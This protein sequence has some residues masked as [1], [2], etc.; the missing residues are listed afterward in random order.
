MKCPNCGQEIAA[1]HLYC[2]KC[3]MEIRI[4]PDFEPEIE[5]SITETLST[6]AEAIEEKVPEKKEGRSLGEKHAEGKRRKKD[7]LGEESGRNWMLVRMVSFISVMLVAVFVV[8]FIYFNYS[9]SYQVE[10]ARRYAE[11]EKYEEA[12]TY[13][14]KA[15][16]LDR[17]NVEIVLLKANYCYAMGETKLA[18]DTL[19]ALI[20][21]EQMEY[22]NA[23]K[24]Y[25][26]LIAIYDVQGRYEEINKL[27]LECADDNIVTLF[28][29]YMAMEP[30]FSYVGG[31]YDEIVPLKLSANTTG[32]IYY[33]VDG[34]VPTKNSKV[35]TAPIFL[36][37][38]KYQVSAFFVNDYGI[39]SEVVKNWYEINLTI[40]EK[41]QVL[42]YSGKYEVPTKIAVEAAQEGRIYYTTDGSEPN[43]DSFVYTEPIDMPLG[44]SNFKF[45]VISEAGV[46]SDIVSRSFELKLNTNV[47]TD[48]AIDRIKKALINRDVL[49][50]MQGNAKATEGKYIF[51]YKTIVEI[52]K[53]Y[54]Y[55]LEEYFEDASGNQRK[56]EL[57]YAV[58]I[59][60]GSPNRLI[61]NEQ[62]QMGLI[63]LTD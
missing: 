37:S 39:E 4:V 47:T 50:D 25:E 32:T 49:K 27:L 62:G 19:L 8:M 63:S 36:E 3:G 24:A 60:S 29:N 41:P 46:S 35:Y 21:K 34:S 1:E 22:E 42:L 54:Y 38:G 18:A 57:L 58:E 17:S 56:T 10:K 16:E 33:T 48:M 15:I 26:Y 43:E 45:V 52:D 23:E 30:E 51:K 2:E 53:N 61:Y 6:V 40:P 13:L 28:Q 11:Q 5:N 20:E 44:R 59:Y 9:V 12:V 31:S 55:V 7:S 14:D